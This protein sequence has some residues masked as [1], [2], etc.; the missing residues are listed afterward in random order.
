MY[1]NLLLSLLALVCLFKWTDAARMSDEEARRKLY[2][3]AELLDEE[4]A[5]RQELNAALAR[6]QAREFEEVVDAE[7][8]KLKDGAKTNEQPKAP[9][10]VSLGDLL[11]EFPLPNAKRSPNL[12]RQ[13]ANQS[14]RGFGKRK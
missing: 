2:T 4:I 3:L 9:R 8:A 1:T 11:E 10:R 14:A 5:A 6:E 13:L 12:L 7:A